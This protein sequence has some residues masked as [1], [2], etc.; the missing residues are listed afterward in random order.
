MKGL[1]T[2]MLKDNIDINAR[3]NF[4]QSH[5]HGTSISMIQFRTNEDAGTAFP[6]VDVSKKVKTNSNKLSPLPADYIN[7]QNLFSD[8]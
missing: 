3:S 8:R 6:K 5:Y 7:I 2:V 1:F 4:I